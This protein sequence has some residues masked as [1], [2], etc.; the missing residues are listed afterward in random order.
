V[1][2]LLTFCVQTKVGAPFTDFNYKE[3]IL[4]VPYVQWDATEAP[5]Y[6]YRGPFS[7]LPH[8]YLNETEPVIL[9]REWAGDDKELGVIERASSAQGGSFKVTG[10]PM[11]P[12]AGRPIIEAT[13]ATTEAP[14]VRSCLSRACT[15]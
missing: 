2:V 12:F 4:T 5:K 8:L 11:H 10:S 15:V 7:Y 1:P 13:W 9:G 14:R 3:F 6:K